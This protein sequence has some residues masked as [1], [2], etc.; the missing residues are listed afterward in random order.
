M[1]VREDRVVSG[2]RTSADDG[3]V[4][5]RDFFIFT[6]ILLIYEVYGA[7]LLRTHIPS[8]PLGY[9]GLPQQRKS[10]QH[11]ILNTHTKAAQTWAVKASITIPG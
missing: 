3:V 9:E 6:N 4:E 8:A 7:Q 5:N 2:V 10:K 1:L 11:H